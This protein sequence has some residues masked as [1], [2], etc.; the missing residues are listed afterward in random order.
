[1]FRKHGF[2][3]KRGTRQ[4]LKC[5]WRFD[6]LTR[7]TLNSKLL[8]IF[9]SVM[10]PTNTKKFNKLKEE[11]KFSNSWKKAVKKRPHKKHDQLKTID[12]FLR[13]RYVQSLYSL[14][15]YVNEI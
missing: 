15:I 2:L 5:H 14:K 8:R 9:V 7:F 3:I 6:F 1:M 13:L 10:A 4:T 11:G 12:Q